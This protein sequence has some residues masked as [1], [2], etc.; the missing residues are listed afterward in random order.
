MFI[1]KKLSYIFLF[2]LY[3]S[4]F[5]TTYDTLIIGGGPAGLTSG[6]YTSRLGLKTLIAEG[7]IPGGQ[8]MTTHVVE[9]FPGFVEGINGPDLISSMRA[10]S[11]KYGAEIKSYN[12]I[13]IDITA[14]PYKVTL[15][16]HDVIETKS[17]I[18]AT[19]SSPKLLGLDS[20]KALMGKGV[21]TCA[22]C[23]APLYRNKN[24][25]VVG[26]GDSAFEEALMLSEFAKKVIIL[27]R[28]DKFKASNI[29]R[30]RVKS[31]TNIE[32]QT[33]RTVSEIL[34]PKKDCVDSIIVFNIKT[35][36]KETLLCDG[37]FIAIGQEPNT[38]WLKG[39]ISIDD[40]GVIQDAPDGIFAA[41]DI[42]DRRYKQ[43]ITAAGSGCKAAL[44][45]YQ[46]LKLE[47]KTK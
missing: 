34:D 31:K 24:V 18:L 4:A 1:M 20:E 7:D 6:L 40:N 13:D 23:D 30:D 28:T 29:L 21:S 37:L 32:I 16:N 12:V 26:G 41:G 9:N 43:A 11:L 17:L 10:Q 46:Y 39:K 42:V 38:S 47:R 35:Q 14:S 45:A 19:G 15:S 44:D 8:L 27:H 2:F 36:K 5:S 25:I 33:F 22:V 3:V